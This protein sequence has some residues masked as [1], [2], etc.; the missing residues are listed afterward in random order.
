M[1]NT[2]ELIDSIK[3]MLNDL[4]HHK[5]VDLKGREVIAA[6]IKRLKDHDILI[7]FLHEGAIEEARRLKR[8]MCK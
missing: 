4:E 3:S 5:G 1:M 8:E 2:K 6:I 7:T